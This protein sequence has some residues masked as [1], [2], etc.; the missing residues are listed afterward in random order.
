MKQADK[1][2]IKPLKMLLNKAKDNVDAKH[3]KDRLLS[4]L[5]EPWKKDP[6]PHD[7]IAK[8]RQMAI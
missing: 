1:A 7:E 8:S 6:N 3:E 4:E 2:L 5:H